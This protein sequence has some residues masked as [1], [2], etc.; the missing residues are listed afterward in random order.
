[1]IV[2]ALV[3]VL[4]GLA[5]G[6]VASAI[7]EH[8]PG[9]NERWLA[10][11]ELEVARPWQQS[12]TP[13]TRLLRDALAAQLTSRLETLETRIALMIDRALVAASPRAFDRVTALARIASDATVVRRFRETSQL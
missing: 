2:A 12:Q 13:P 8:V 1:M 9:T 7:A 5:R 4:D 11:A 6:L 3:E 10:A